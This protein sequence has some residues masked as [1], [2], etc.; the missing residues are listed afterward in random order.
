MVALT[1]LQEE[2]ARDGSWECPYLLFATL[3]LDY[4]EVLL[5]WA[6]PTVQPEWCMFCEMQS[7]CDFLPNAQFMLSTHHTP[8]LRWAEK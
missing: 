2:D 8:A 1:G 5:T 4:D 7:L 6:F 3:P